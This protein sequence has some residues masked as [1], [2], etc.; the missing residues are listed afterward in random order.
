M[1]PN[2]VW[3]LLLGAARSLKVFAPNAEYEKGASSSR[4]A[5]AAP[6]QLLAPIAKKHFEFLPTQNTGE[7]GRPAPWSSLLQL[8]AA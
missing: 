4:S 6:S 1:A 8:A 3:A 7:A 2:E 5:D